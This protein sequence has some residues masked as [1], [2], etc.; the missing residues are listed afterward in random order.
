MPSIRVPKNNSSGTYFITI[1]VKNWY[2]VLDRYHR[3]N[4]LAKSLQWFQKN[5]ELKI[6][7]FVFMINHLHIIIRSKDVIEFI[8]D[9]K[10]F[11]A[12]EILGNIKKNEPRALKLF[13]KKSGIFEFWS[14][15]NMPEFI[16]SEKFLNQK[17][18][19]IQDNPVK[20]I[21]VQKPED[22]YWS[23]ANLNCELKINNWYCEG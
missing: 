12:R 8:R 4:I 1:T 7:A 21:Y 9:F 5:K 14:K 23:S 3:W 19:Y 13:E 17:I 16:G 10:K 2:Y 6:Y 18:K 15:T 22:W 11:T 20:R